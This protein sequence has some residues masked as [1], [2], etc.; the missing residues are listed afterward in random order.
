MRQI[1]H[2]LEE[3][4]VPFK[5]RMSASTQ[6]S[7]A[8]QMLAFE[9]PCPFCGRDASPHS[10]PEEMSRTY[11][12]RDIALPSRGSPRF[13]WTGNDITPSYNNIILI[14]TVDYRVLS[15]YITYVNC[16]MPQAGFVT[17]TV[18]IPFTPGQTLGLNQHVKTSAI[19][20][21]PSISTA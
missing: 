18:N 20:Y 1:E 6:P 8:V 10:P 7:A 5:C 11:V 2:N 19:R 15:I 17:A 4:R 3:A 14:K 21:C 13:S 9:I 16:V 12:R